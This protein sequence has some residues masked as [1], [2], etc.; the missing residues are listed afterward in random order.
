MILAKAVGLLTLCVGALAQR[1]EID[2]YLKDPN[3]V[4]YETPT[5]KVEEWIA[6]GDS[7][8]ARASAYSRRWQ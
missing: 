6:L 4:H 8:T 7:Y 3:F 5:Q 2:S 1:E